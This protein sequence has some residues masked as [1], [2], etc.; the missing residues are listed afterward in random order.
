MSSAEGQSPERRHIASDSAAICHFDQGAVRR[1]EKSRRSRIYNINNM[2]NYYVYI[3]TNYTNTVLYI[4]VTNDIVRR[5]NEHRYKKDDG[6]A[7]KY[8]AYKLVYMEQSVSIEDA[9]RR[10][11]QLK[12]WSRKKKEDLISSL[13]PQWNDLM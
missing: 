2:T 12:K 10:E 5:V 1:V 13:N 3:M 9:I 8:K 4:G 7:E 6:F 11:K